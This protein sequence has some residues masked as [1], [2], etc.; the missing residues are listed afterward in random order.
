MYMYFHFVFVW[1]EAYASTFEA[2]I[3]NS[4]FNKVDSKVPLQNSD[5]RI[6]HYV[7]LRQPAVG[8][9]TDVS[10]ELPICR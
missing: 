5:L 6:W 9:R 2:T 1:A 4:P 3:S 10:T 8:P 7:T